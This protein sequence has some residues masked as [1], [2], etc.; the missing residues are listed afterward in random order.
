MTIEKGSNSALD[1]VDK[2]WKTK[3]IFA[4]SSCCQVITRPSVQEQ[5]ITLHSR[6]LQE[7]SSIRK[8][9]FEIPYSL[10]YLPSGLDDVT[11][12]YPVAM[13]MFD[14]VNVHRLCCIHED[15]EL[16]INYIQPTVAY[17]KVKIDYSNDHLQSVYVHDGTR[18]NL[19]H[20]NQPK[21][22]SIHFMD[23]PGFPLKKDIPVEYSYG[24]LYQA[25][26]Y[27]ALLTH[28]LKIPPKM[29]M[30]NENKGKWKQQQIETLLFQLLQPYASLCGFVCYPAWWLI[31]PGCTSKSP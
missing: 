6:H 13:T 26:N 14:D 5:I 20:L 31:F 30:L 12:R 9:N 18:P 4:Y 16:G 29:T 11:L 1:Q 22:T 10:V 21:Q 27:V 3:A 7:W 15:N 17:P 25:W 19:Y 24:N 23:L 2:E 28:K 8:T